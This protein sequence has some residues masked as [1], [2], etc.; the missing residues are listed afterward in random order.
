VSDEAKETFELGYN[1]LSES[2]GMDVDHT[3]T[4]TDGNG[5]LTGSGWCGGDSRSENDKV[6]GSFEAVLGIGEACWQM[7]VP[8]LLDGMGHVPEGRDRLCPR[9][10]A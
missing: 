7:A 2:M 8:G 9:P 6:V 5:A 1:A 10:A 3:P 4:E